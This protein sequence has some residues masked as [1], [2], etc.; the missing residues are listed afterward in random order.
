MFNILGMMLSGIVIGYFLRNFSGVG[1]IHK[2]IFITVILLLFMLGLSIG[3]NRLIIEN[4]FK[5]YGDNIIYDDF[6]ML[7]NRG[8]RVA[9]TGR[10]GSGKS[11]LLRMLA[12]ADKD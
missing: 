7:I 8:E 12:G 4:L 5:A 3:M 9:I 1:K 2:P 6:S 10:N 11:T